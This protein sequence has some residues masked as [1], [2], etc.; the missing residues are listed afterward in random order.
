MRGRRIR[1]V[2]LE[3]RRRSRRRIIAKGMGRRWRRKRGR[4]KLK[5]EGQETKGV[6]E[7]MELDEEP[8][9]VALWL[10]GR[11]GKEA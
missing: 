11:R 7:G 1:K 5:V 3:G 8:T 10:I 6:V 2:L 9:N 4:R